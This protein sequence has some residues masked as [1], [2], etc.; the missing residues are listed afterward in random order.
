MNQIV[1]ELTKDQLKTEVPNFK[2]G[3]GVK[4]TNAECR[5]SQE[6]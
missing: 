5:F 6:S 1:S 2:V 4:A 3:D